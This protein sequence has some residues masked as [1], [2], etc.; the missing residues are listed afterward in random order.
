M[1][2]S[3]KTSA[4]KLGLGVSATRDPFARIDRIHNLGLEIDDLAIAIKKWRN[5]LL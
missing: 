4:E 1:T 2:T 3:K 5:G